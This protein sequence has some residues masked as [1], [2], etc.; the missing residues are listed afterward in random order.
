M[1]GKNFTRRNLKKLRITC[2]VLNNSLSSMSL[3]QATAELVSNFTFAL[4]I[5][6]FIPGYPSTSYQ[7]YNHHNYYYYGFFKHYWAGVVSAVGKISA[8]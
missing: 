6:G 5:R 2:F 7:Y 3:L 4:L 1:Q 8:F